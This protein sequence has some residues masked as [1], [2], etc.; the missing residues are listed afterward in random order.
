[1][2]LHDYEGRRIAG[3]AKLVVQRLR[4]VSEQG[5]IELAGGEENWQ[6]QRLQPGQDGGLA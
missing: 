1:M 4:S 5:R 3:L 2:P 6:F